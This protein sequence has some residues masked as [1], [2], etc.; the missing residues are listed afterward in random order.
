MDHSLPI[1][2]TYFSEPAVTYKSNL[3]NT[4]IFL[5]NLPSPFEAKC[6]KA[7]SFRK[8]LT[9]RPEALPLDPMQKMARFF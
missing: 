3:Q 8:P 7:F 9:S 5:A 2:R 6:S 1:E 4:E